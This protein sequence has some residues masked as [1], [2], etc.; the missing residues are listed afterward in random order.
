M[1]KLFTLGQQDTYKISNCTIDGVDAIFKNTLS[2]T[3]T[4]VRADFLLEFCTVTGTLRKDGKVST[5][6]NGNIYAILAALNANTNNLSNILYTG[7]YY[8]Y[9]AGST[10]IRG[11]QGRIYEGVLELK[12]DDYLEIKVNYPASCLANTS[13]Y[14]SAAT[15]T[16]TISESLTVSRMTSI[17][18][19]DV[20]PVNTTDSNYVQSF[21]DN[22]DVL[23]LIDK[24]Y[25]FTSAKEF[26]TI[27]INGN[28]DTRVLNL[29]QLLPKRRA[30]ASAGTDLVLYQGI[31]QK[32]SVQATFNSPSANNNYFVTRSIVTTENILLRANALSD[33]HT[34][35]QIN[36]ILN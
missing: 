16:L 5:I 2:G 32:L 9:T 4:P 6:I 3:G 19:I 18:K 13:A 27:T 26:Q 36:N 24:A 23:M 33:R 17:S 10:G 29:D 22:T 35:E 31:P 12:G 28:K 21:P 25:V 30:Q 7:T 8:T 34:R 11:L 20:F 1:S 14:G 15:C